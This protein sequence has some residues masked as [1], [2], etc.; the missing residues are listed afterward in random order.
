MKTSIKEMQTPSLLT[1]ITYTSHTQVCNFWL[2]LTRTKQISYQPL[3]IVISQDTLTSFLEPLLQITYLTVM[4][5]EDDLC[6][7]IKITKTKFK[8]L[9][10]NNDRDFFKGFRQFKTIMSAT[11]RCKQ[12]IWC[13]VNRVGKSVVM[14]LNVGFTFFFNR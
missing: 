6:V 8:I 7:A 13:R 2:K 1:F 10:F 9:N 12:T 11:N 3:K 14:R 4:E 5:C